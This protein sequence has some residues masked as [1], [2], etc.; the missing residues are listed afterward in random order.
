MSVRDSI[1]RT[2]TASSTPSSPAS[3][4]EW[5]WGWRCAARSS[6]LM[7]AT[8]GHHPSCPMAAS[9]SLPCRQGSI[10]EAPTMRLSEA[11]PTV[12]VIDDDED[13]REGLQ[14]LLGSIGLRVELFASVQEFLGSARPDRP[15]SEEHTS[16]L[17]SH[18]NL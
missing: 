18:L 2:W 15:R 1:Q 4:K 5:A 14:G 7:A 12:V 10:G 13:I 11:Q 16:E 6:R 8:Y 17:Q 9:F 3:R